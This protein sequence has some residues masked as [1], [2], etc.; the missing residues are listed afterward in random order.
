MHFDF[1]FPGKT[2][3][4]YCVKGIDNFHK[5]LKHFV[6]ADIR[7]IKEKSKPT[8]HESKEHLEACRTLEAHIR[9]PSYVVMLDSRG[10]QLSSKTLAQR[11]SDW[12]N[13]GKHHITFIVGGPLGFTKEVLE[14]ADMVLSLSKMTFPHDLARVILLEQL[15]RAFTIKAGT[16]Y[17][18]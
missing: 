4:P 12:E 11:I 8:V 5:R 17:H 15:Y 9:K 3:E 2:K 6:K 1:L 10:E 14:K 18:K 16:G 7:I 13:Q